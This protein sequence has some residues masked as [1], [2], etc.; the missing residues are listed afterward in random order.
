[1]DKRHQY[2]N[3]IVQIGTLNQLV[4]EPHRHIET[5]ILIVLCDPIVPMW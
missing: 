4:N 3:D 5:E 1:M 2:R